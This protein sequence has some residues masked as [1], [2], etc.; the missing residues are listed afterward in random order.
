[1]KMCSNARSVPLRREEM[2]G[3]MLSKETSR[4]PPRGGGV[5]RCHRAVGDRIASAAGVSPSTTDRTLKRAG[6]SKVKD[7]EPEE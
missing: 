6:P 2:A 5:V 1:M 3:S 4:R 7:L